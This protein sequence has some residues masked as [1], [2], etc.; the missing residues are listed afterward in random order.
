MELNTSKR[1]RGSHSTKCKNTN[2]HFVVP[3][4]YEERNP[5]M[6]IRDLVKQS[7][8]RDVTLSDVA[9]FGR[10]Q[11]SRMKR[12]YKDRA[13]AIN[14]L[15]SVFSAHVNLVTFQV[16]ISLRNASDLAGLTTVSDAEV[17]KSEEDKLHT[18]IVSISRASRALKDMVEMGVIRADKEWQV[19]DKEAGCWIDKYFEATPL[20]FQMV[21]VTPERLEKERNKRLG[22]LKHQA[23][24]NGLTP[25]QVGR[26]SITQ[27][28]AQNQLQWR[29]RAFERRA[30]EQ[31]RKKMQRQLEGKTRE[32]QRN[33]AQASL[34]NTLSNDELRNMSLEQYKDLVN[35]NIA[36]QRKFANVSPPLH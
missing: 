16:E 4:S 19:W 22:Y 34:L 35:Q 10:A 28:K 6:F 17:K 29:K 32:Q 33:I 30:K 14:A 18:P 12:I 24:E 5:P 13:K 7:Q 11:A 26:M 20:F 23:I 27:L 3:K 15:H 25:E 9:M 36:M 2:P 31:A 8:S 1:V 21:G